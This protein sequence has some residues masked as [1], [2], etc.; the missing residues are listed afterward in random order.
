VNSI[1]NSNLVLYLPLHKTDGD[2]FMSRDGYGHVVT[3]TGALWTPQGRTFDGTDD[4]INCGAAA[5]LAALT[6]NM[7]IESWIKPISL[8][9]NNLGRILDKTGTAARGFYL[10]MSATAKVLFCIYVG[11][12]L[13]YAA[14]AA[15]SVPFGTWAHITGVFNG[16]NVLICANGVWS[17]GDTTA[18]PIDAHSSDDLLIGDTSASL[19]CFNGSIGEVRIYNRALSP[20]EVTHNYLAT[21]WR[22]Q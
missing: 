13:K 10:T 18:G 4:V 6:D 14:S 1:L 22:Y 15:N 7:T 20:V 17:T 11:G 8:G 12:V 2:S 9:E 19:R 3:V 16:T 21:K 5:A